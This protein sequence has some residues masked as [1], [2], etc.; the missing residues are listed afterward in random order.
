MF[1][2]QNIELCKLEEH[3]LR[4]LR[5]LKRDSWQSTHQVTL[6]S[7]EDQRQWFLS[8]L[9]HNIH[10]PRDL[11]LMARTKV[12]L[13]SNTKVGIFKIFG[14]DYVN[15]TADVGWDLFKEFRGKGLGKQLVNAGSAFC[16]DILALRRLTAEILDNN[17]ASIKCAENAGFVL[18]GRKRQ[19]VHRLGNYPD[20]LIYGSLVSDRN[21]ALQPKIQSV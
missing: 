19:A 3:D 10:S 21:L 14:V 15:S 16:F 12:A 8:T 17:P 2:H 5:D 18:E 6:T 7:I 1:V 4:F 11:I 20:S 13:L 9:D